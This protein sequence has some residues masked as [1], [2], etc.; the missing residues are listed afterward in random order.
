MWLWQSSHRRFDFERKHFFSLF[1][2]F[3]SPRIV[4]VRVWATWK[5]QENVWDMGRK[6]A[7]QMST[8]SNL[9]LFIDKNFT[10]N[11]TSGQWPPL[12]DVFHNSYFHLETNKRCQ[13]KN[14]WKVGPI[15]LKWERSTDRWTMALKGWQC[16]DPCT[17]PSNDV[18]ESSTW[19]A[20][21]KWVYSKP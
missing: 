2:M 16:V 13:I 6:S 20:V 17:S 12:E 10:E 5:F 9:I 14:E 1:S 11:V 3:W 15:V 19:S 21:G 7:N 8:I 4:T 18:H